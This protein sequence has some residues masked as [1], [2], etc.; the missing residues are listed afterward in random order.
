MDNLSDYPHFPQILGNC[1]AV[2]HSTHNTTT[3]NFQLSK[4]ESLTLYITDT[5]TQRM[6]ENGIGTIITDI[7]VEF[8]TCSP[9]IAYR[10]YRRKLFLLAGSKYSVP[11]KLRFMIWKGSRKKSIKSR[12]KLWFFSAFVLTYFLSWSKVEW[13]TG[14]IWRLTILSKAN[15]RRKYAIS[16]NLCSS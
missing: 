13:K 16:Y 14:R 6:M 7:P 3:I 2:T 4:N 5:E 15:E 10:P 8:L 11:N 9:S 12:N 1:F